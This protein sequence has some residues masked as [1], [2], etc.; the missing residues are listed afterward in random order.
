MQAIQNQ[1]E[2]D[3]LRKK[4]NLCIDE[5]DKLE[6]HVKNLETKLEAE[7]SSKVAMKEETQK[8]QIDLPSLTTDQMPNIALNDQTELK[9]M[10][11]AI[12]AASQ[13]EAQAHETAIV[14]SKENDELRMKLKVLVEDNNK[15][16]ELYERAAEENNKNCNRAQSSQENKAEDEYN[17]LTELA[18]GRES[19]MKKEVENLEHQLME[20][21]EEN[22]KLM[23]LY[24]KAMQ[25]RDEFKKILAS[26]GQRI[27]ENKGGFDCAEKLVEVDGEERHKSDESSAFG[28]LVL[29]E[30]E[31]LQL[32]NLAE[33]G[34]SEIAL[35][36]TNLFAAN[37]QTGYIQCSGKSEINDYLELQESPSSLE[38]KKFIE[39]GYSDFN[40]Q[41]RAESSETG[42]L[43]VVD[44]GYMM[45]ETCFPGL[46]ERDGSS[47]CPEDLHINAGDQNGD[48]DQGMD[49]KS[50]GVVRVKQPHD[51]KLVRMKLDKAQEKLLSSAQTIS[52][53][54][55]LER[56]SI[57]VDKLSIE[58]EALETGMQLMQQEC[59]SSQFL[60][61]EMQERRDVM[62]KKL[63]ALKY[64]LS[65]FSSSIGYFEQR[66]AQARA[67][68]D[69]S[70]AYLNRKK[71]ELTSLQTRKY[72]IEVAQMKIQQTQ[73]EL[74]RN[75]V[76]WISR[77]EEE[78]RRQENERVL[79]AIDNVEKTDIHP[80][81]KN[82]P[83]SGKATELLKSE[84]EKTKLQT[85]VKQAQEKLVVFRREVEDLDRKL[86]K[87]DREIQVV[88]MEIQKGLK[89][90]EEMEHRLGSV[91]QERDMV[92]EMKENG[93]NEVE[94][95]ILEYHQGVFEAALKEE[96]MKILEEELDMELRRI[97]ELQ[98]AKAIASRRKT[99]L[100]EEFTCQ[101][102]FVSDKME[103]ELQIIQMSIMELKSLYGQDGPNDS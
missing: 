19:E 66:E 23:S 85:E 20:M 27:V 3:A 77:I 67:R 17:D 71:E 93:R 22:E 51:L 48:N 26:G 76:D 55:S 16:I 68:V 36:E 30:R 40:V 6:R 42:K 88:Q 14:L 98:T 90:V 74:K 100:L 86:G 101:S 102:C 32:E 63:R 39:S 25:E 12:A 24:E 92:L 94:N 82:W 31:D 91:I 21:H 96:E 53:F 69:A 28:P 10:V 62:D 72:E 43:T 70:S 73:V 1:S 99:Q 38:P 56:A 41:D 37:V 45:E 34:Q 59:A 87:V 52:I 15:L 44:K 84:E 95:M 89:S 75:L 35:D 79:F 13:R 9:T 7:R 83:L 78:N 54:G 46:N 33:H 49:A 103:E 11:D 60:S 61:S 29:S 64:S 65:N 8:L 18:V 4:L 58:M 47:H 81:Q 5:K 50:I 97:E 2:L 57:E 80:A